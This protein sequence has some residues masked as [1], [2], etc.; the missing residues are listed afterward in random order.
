MSADD[1]G[2]CII[3]LEK[4]LGVVLGSKR[5]LLLYRAG[6]GCTIGASHSVVQFLELGFTQGPIP[7]PKFSFFANLYNLGPMESAP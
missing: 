7:N 2:C 1:A 6:K 4:V 5:F 3:G